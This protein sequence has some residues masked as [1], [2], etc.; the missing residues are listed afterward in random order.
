[1]T[2]AYAT[3]NPRWKQ[4]ILGL[5]LDL[6]CNNSTSQQPLTMELA[7]LLTKGTP[8]LHFA[9]LQPCTCWFLHWKQML[10]QFAAL[11]T[12][13]DWR[14]FDQGMLPLHCACQWQAEHNMVLWQNGNI[15]TLSVHAPPI[16]WTL[17]C[18]VI[19]HHP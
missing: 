6:V 12:F 5:M 9:C 19:C 2:I 17:L 16:P 4:M 18:I 10:E 15:L 8:P 7:L 11:S 3:E 14:H 13:E 1:M